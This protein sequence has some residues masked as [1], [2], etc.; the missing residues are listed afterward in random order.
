MTAILRDAG[1]RPLLQRQRR[2]RCAGMRFTPSADG[3]RP[4]FAAAERADAAFDPQ[5]VRARQR[6]IAAI[7]LAVI[8]IVDLAGPFVR[9]RGAHAREQ[10]KPDY[11]ALRQR[12]IRILV[13]DLRFAGRG[14]SGLLEPDHDAAN[15]SGAFADAHLGVSSLSQPDTVDITAGLSSR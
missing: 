4:G 8:G 9:S 2:S 10:R 1:K 13:V 5:R 3:P 7:A 15:P 14:I 6:D 11:W 12:R